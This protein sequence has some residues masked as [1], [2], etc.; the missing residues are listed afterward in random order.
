MTEKVAKVVLTYPPEIW[1]RINPELE[2]MAL[3]TK[4][5]YCVTKLKEG[6]INAIPFSGT[7][8]QTVFNKNVVAKLKSMGIGV[9]F[10]PEEI[11]QY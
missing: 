1:Q 8:P 9:E 2:A 6:I 10:K 3:G 4:G 5:F 7:D 11:Q